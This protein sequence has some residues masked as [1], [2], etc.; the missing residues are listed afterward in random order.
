MAA[1]AA[2]EPVAAAVASCWT[3]A[4]AVVGSAV[5]VGLISAVSVL[6]AVAASPWGHPRQLHLLFLPVVVAAAAAAV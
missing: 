1:A 3:P 4:A 6:E 5:A 2:V